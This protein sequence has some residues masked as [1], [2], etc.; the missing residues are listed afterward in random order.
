MLSAFHV[1]YTYSSALQA[2]FEYKLINVCL[3]DVVQR[4]YSHNQRRHFFTLKSLR[5]EQ[6]QVLA[7]LKNKAEVFTQ[8]HTTKI[9]PED[10]GNS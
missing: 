2:R 3:F 5:R 7:L 6:V 4:I 8:S 9:L 10:L 1:C